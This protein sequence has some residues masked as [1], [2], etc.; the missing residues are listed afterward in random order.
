MNLGTS[1]M[2]IF[3]PG[4]KLL[5]KAFT[6]V[7]LCMTFHV[8]IGVWPEKG[9][10]WLGWGRVEWVMIAV[11]GLHYNDC[12]AVQPWDCCGMSETCDSH[13]HNHAQLPTLPHHHHCNPVSPTEQ[14]FWQTS[15]FFIMAPI[16]KGSWTFRG[17]KWR[18]GSLN[19]P[20]S[21]NKSGVVF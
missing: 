8:Q 17:N 19:R 11:H 2:G 16:T 5:V 15:I 1:W 10:S 12:T 18:R 20:L 21:H 4:G 9:T 14:C 3:W 7:Y 6:I 13:T